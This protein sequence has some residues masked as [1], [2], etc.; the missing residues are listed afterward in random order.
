MCMGEWKKALEEVGESLKLR[1]R[2]WR[3]P[4]KDFLKTCI[5]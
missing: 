4:S 1:N 5:L 2:A 3:I